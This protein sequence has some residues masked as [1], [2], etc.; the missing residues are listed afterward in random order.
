[1][2]LTMAGVQ[3]LLMHWRHS[4]Q[5]WYQYININTQAKSILYVEQQHKP[6]TPEQTSYIHD[7][8]FQLCL[9]PTLPTQ[10]QP[11]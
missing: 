10:H 4:K 6:I 2:T 1:M 9:L 7:L 8:I 11:V 3:H 5:H